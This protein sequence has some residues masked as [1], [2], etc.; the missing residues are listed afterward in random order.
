[1]AIHCLPVLFCIPSI[2]IRSATRLYPDRRLLRLAGAGSTGLV[3]EG[4]SLF[5]GPASTCSKTLSSE[6]FEAIGPVVGAIFSRL[7]RLSHRR[8]S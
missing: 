3:G 5:P 2:E 6:A 7:G 4:T 1:V 8:A